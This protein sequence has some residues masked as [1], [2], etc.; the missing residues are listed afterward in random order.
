MQIDLSIIIINWNTRDILRQCLELIPAA[1]GDLSFEL[2]LVDNGSTDGSQ[3]MVR[4]HFP[5]A[6]LV[7]NKENLGF[8]KAVNQGIRASTGKYLALVNSDVMIPAG[9]L[10][11]LVNYLQEHPQVAAVGPQLMG[12]DGRLQRSGGFAP[13]P[14]RALKHIIPGSCGLTVRSRAADG[15]LPVDWLCAACMVM[16]EKVVREVGMLDDSHFM[17]AEDMEYG[18]RLKRAG[19]QLHLLP[20]VRVIHLGRASSTGISAADVL[21]LAASFRVAASELS[22]SAYALFGILRTL[23][24]VT[25]FTLLRLASLLSRAARVRAGLLGLYARTALK[26]TLRKP[27]YATDLCNELESQLLH[28]RADSAK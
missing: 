20:G 24:I 17:Y 22:P 6:R 15:F 7:A 27:Q 2:I 28:A 3:V 12:D 25:R 9:V 18:L 16:P 1:V 5:W 14:V 26:L 4:S 13:T 21:W 23:G 11:R 19:W 8:P 10:S